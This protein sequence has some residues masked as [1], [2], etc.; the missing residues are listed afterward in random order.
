LNEYICFAA[1]DLEAHPRFVDFMAEAIEQDKH[2]AATV[3]WANG[4]LQSCGGRGNDCCGLGCADW[5]P[6]EWSPTPF[7]RRDWWWDILD[8]HADMLA[9]LHYA[10]DILVSALLEREGI[11]SI[12]R[13]PATLTHHNHPVGRDHGRA[14]PDVEKCRAYLA[15]LLV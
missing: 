9:E 3:L 11:P 12:Y 1:D 4:H 5:Q 2:P 14:R 13:A 8:Q 15:Q 10:S 7:L 6:V